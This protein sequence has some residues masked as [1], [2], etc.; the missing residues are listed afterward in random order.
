MIT[1]IPKNHMFIESIQNLSANI[2]DDKE[3]L[4]KVF[5]EQLGFHI[6]NMSLSKGEKS[7]VEHI[8]NKLFEDRKCS[9]F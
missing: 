1:K 3:F 4:C 6:S 2:G 7:S 8:S 9:E 5:S